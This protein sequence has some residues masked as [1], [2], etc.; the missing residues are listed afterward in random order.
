M[1]NKSIFCSIFRSSYL[2][3][4]LIILGI[5]TSG[6]I[7]LFAQNLEVS[8]PDTMVLIKGQKVVKSIKLINKADAD[9][10][11]ELI[12]FDFLSKKIPK[13]NGKIKITGLNELT[14]GQGDSAEIS[15]VFP[16][17]KETGEYDGFLY[18]N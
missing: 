5:L 3:M 11:I 6:S 10:K 7:T 13:K 14:L 18:Y 2:N 16:K 12:K 15:I 9:L 1:E 17:Y 4:F 8:A